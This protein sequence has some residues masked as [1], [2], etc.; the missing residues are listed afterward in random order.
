MRLL[1]Y[2]ETCI[3]WSW[4][5]WEHSRTL[6]E[7]AHISKVKKDNKSRIF[8]RWSKRLKLHRVS[9]IHTCVRVCVN[10]SLAPAYEK[11]TS[12]SSASKY[13]RH[14]RT[15]CFNGDLSR[16]L[17]AVENGRKV[18]MTIIK[19]K[20]PTILET[21]RDFNIYKWLKNIWRKFS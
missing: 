12:F 13:H 20:T 8:P 19:G 17:F 1:N 18:P 15:D 16:L 21:R 2:F 5:D 10:A 9:R 14:Y 7:V 6:L 3:L 4:K 11:W